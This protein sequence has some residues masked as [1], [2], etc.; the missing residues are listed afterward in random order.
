[1]GMTYRQLQELTK[2]VAE[3]KEIF[4][5]ISVVPLDKNGKLILSPVDE[6]EMLKIRRKLKS[7]Q[8]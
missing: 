4:M 3:T 8:E 7:P 2:K 1:M 5:E 6:S